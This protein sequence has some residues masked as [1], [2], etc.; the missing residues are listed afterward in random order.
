MR[1]TKS[2]LIYLFTIFPFLIIYGQ[3]IND[4]QAG[5]ITM[6]II[7]DVHADILPDAKERMDVF[8]AQANDI[9]ADLIIQLGDFCRPNENEKF[10]MESWMNFPG[11]RYHVLGN[12]DMDFNTKKETIEYW[13]MP[14]PYYSFDQNGFHFIVLD[15]NYLYQDGKYID[16]AHANFYVESEDRAYINPEQM[17]WLKEDLQKTDK[18]CLLF[19]HQS[20]INVLWGI[21]NRVEIQEIL[22]QANE[23]AGFQ[24]VIACFNG[25][26]HVDFHR[27]INGIHYFEINSA[28][29]QW[30]GEGYADENCYDSTLASSYHHLDKVAIY[31]DPLFAFVTIT[32][33]QLILKGV[34]S[35]WYCESPNDKG[36]PK[37]PYGCEYSPSISNYSVQIQNNTTKKQK[38]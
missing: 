3:N 21:N 32:Q 25:H 18:R 11:N 33:E 38:P 13:G 29:Y 7:S 5:E 28:G 15:A 6:G 17:A 16:Y 27:E 14:A 37:K 2:I 8:I 23:E 22:E 34:A 31:K 19:S 36:I 1:K 4:D 20:L 12:H 26:D 10:M 35:E 9:D 24:K 30:M